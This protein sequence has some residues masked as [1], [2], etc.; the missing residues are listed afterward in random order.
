MSCGLYKLVG[1]TLKGLLVNDSY[2]LTFPPYFCPQWNVSNKLMRMGGSNLLWHYLRVKN[3]GR[4]FHC[5]LENRVFLVGW[6]T[7]VAFSCQRKLR[8]EVTRYDCHPNQLLSKFQWGIQFRNIQV[9]FFL[10]LILYLWGLL[11]FLSGHWFTNGK[12]SDCSSYNTQL[13]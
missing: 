9:L 12:A 3:S 13:W 8:V 1:V 6:S 10:P 7:E 11:V 2:I 5:L 4:R